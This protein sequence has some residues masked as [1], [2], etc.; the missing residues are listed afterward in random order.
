MIQDIKLTAVVV[1][2]AAISLMAQSDKQKVCPRLL[3]NAPM[4]VNIEGR[5]VN[6]QKNRTSASIE[7]RHHNETLDTFFVNLYDSPSF[8]FITA[9]SYRYM[10]IGD[11]KVKRQLGLHHLKEKV[12][13]TPLRLD[14]L[15]LLANGFFKCP[16]STRLNMP[17][18]I[19]ATAYSN[20]WWSLVTDSLPNPEKVV[21]HGASKNRYFTI[22]NWKSY[23]GEL[24]PTLVNVASGDYGGNL[25]IRSAYPAQA[26]EADPLRKLEKPKIL[27]P[28]PKLFRKIT[29]MEGER[30]IPLILK[31]NKQLLGE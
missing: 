11:S 16:D 26:L 25:W 2:I 8:T 19:L 14:D 15:E 17:N 9:G 24:L 1:C 23:A 3:T 30:K 27:F 13:K 4:I 29:A 22:S 7:W 21:M 12:G 20:M 28:V 18:S 6:E 31:L 5:F 10:L